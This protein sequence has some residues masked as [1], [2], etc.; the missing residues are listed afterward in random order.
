MGWD[1]EG[2]AGLQISGG[3]CQGPPSLEELV[4]GRAGLLTTKG[5]RLGPLR[6]ALEG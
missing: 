4:T 5:E 2:E 6:S 3:V 1:V